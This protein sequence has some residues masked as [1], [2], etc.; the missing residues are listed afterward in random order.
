MLQAPAELDC[1]APEPMAMFWYP[2]V[3]VY[4]A[5]VPRAVLLPPD[6]L[7]LSACLPK[8]TQIGHRI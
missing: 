3:L 6:V 4:K 2:V 1:N 5:L 8:A 7:L